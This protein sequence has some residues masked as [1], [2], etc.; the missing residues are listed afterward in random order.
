MRRVSVC[1]TPNYSSGVMDAAVEAHFQALGLDSLLDPGMRVTIKA[2]LLMKRVPDEAT[3]THP[4]LVRAIVRSLKK[5]GVSAITIADSPGGPYTVQAL[6][7]IYAA[8]GME[9]V[10]REEGVL[11]NRDTGYEEVAN[12]QGR[13]VKSFQLI[14]P[15]TRADLVINAAKLKTHCMTGLSGGV[16]NLFGCVPGLMKPEFH[17]RFPEKE[18][19]CEMLVD[20]CECVRPAVT[21]V[22]AVVAMEGNGPSGGNPR[23]VGLTFAGRNPYA[24]DVALCRAIGEPPASIPILQ[25]AIQRGLCPAGTEELSL[26]GDAADFTTVE[27]FAKPT[28]HKLDFSTNIPAPLRPLLLPLV[29]RV[30]TPKPVIQSSRCIGC[31]KCA[32]SCPAHTIALWERKAVIDYSGCIKCYCCHEMCPV[33]AISVR[34]LGLFTHKKGGR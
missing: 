30:L 12:P 21:F 29:R 16:K 8:S 28:P 14:H 25:C 27:G 24:V 34:R 19:F 10:A 7:G 5:R 23:E 20:L 3:T 1:R 15:V 6:N 9:Q 33:R 32:E 11:L 18:R 31:G 26:V 22:D 2:N 17:Y 4:A 13:L